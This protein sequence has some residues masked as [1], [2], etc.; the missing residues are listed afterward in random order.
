[1]GWV[2]LDDGIMENPKVAE[3]SDAAFRAYIALIVYCRR[4]GTGGHVGPGAMRVTLGGAKRAARARQILV[5]S[6]LLEET[7]RGY[8][9]HDW[10][11]WNKAEMGRSEAG[12]KA[13]RARWDKEK[14]HANRNAIASPTAMPSHRERDALSLSLSLG[15]SVEENSSSQNRTPVRARD[16]EETIVNHLQPSNDER[17]AYALAALANRDLAARQAAPNAAPVTNPVAWLKA[18]AKRRAEQHGT[19][20]ADIAKANPDM[21]IADL[22]DAVIAKTTTADGQPF[23]TRL[24]EQQ[25]AMLAKA[26]ENLRQ[27][28]RDRA[29]PR[30]PNRMNR[31]AELRDVLAPP[32][33]SDGPPT[34][35]DAA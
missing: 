24:D 1:M 10:E 12:R 17:I 8:R 13:A 14:G 25:T 21:S 2:Y 29:I 19:L 3:L 34:N 4:N 9:I 18:A 6:H 32:P 15:S 26:D 5:R 20:I 31:L 11:E 35:G 27:V 30:D 23:D 22:A 16:E 33:R 7:E 28:E